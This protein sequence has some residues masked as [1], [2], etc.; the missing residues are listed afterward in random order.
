MLGERGVTPGLGTILVGDDPN[1]DAYVRLKREDSAE[2][3]VALVPRRAPRDR[4]PGR[5]LA[6]IDEF[7]AD[8]DVD[9]FIVQVPL[10]KQLDDEGRAER[11]IPARTPTGCTRSTS[12]D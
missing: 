5:V 12:G 9:A 7:N 6:A 11:S 2:V 1:S 4:D 3:G 10:P 8:P